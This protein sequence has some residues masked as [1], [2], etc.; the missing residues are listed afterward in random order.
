MQKEREIKKQEI[1]QDIKVLRGLEKSKSKKRFLKISALIILFIV[2]I[3]LSFFIGMNLIEKEDFNDTI[4]NDSVVNDSDQLIP[5]FNDTDI[6]NQTNNTIITPSPGGSSGGKGDDEGCT[7]DCT[8]KE[9]GNDGCGGICGVCEV[10][11]YCDK[12]SCVEKERIQNFD[13]SNNILILYNENSLDAQEIAEYYADARGMDYKQICHIKLPLG[14]FAT[15]EQLIG[16]RKVI[17]EECLCNLVSENLVGECNISRIKE[18]AAVSPITHLAIIR[19]IPPR[20]TGT[21][22]PADEEEPSLDFYLA[23][24]LY[25]DYNIFEVEGYG[26]FT[27][28]HYH[29]ANPDTLDYQP[30]F[31]HKGYIRD[32]D[33]ALDEF[34]AYGRVEAMTKERTFELIDRTIAAEKKGVSGNF[35]V[36]L[37]NYPQIGQSIEVYD[38]FRRLTSDFTPKCADYLNV[39]KWPYEECR[40]GATIGPIPGEPGKNEIPLAINAGIFLGHE[41]EGNGHN[42][43]DG[44]NNM[45]NWRKTDVDCITLCKDMPTEL[46]KQECKANSKD[47]F[48]EIN[49]DCVGVAD[50]FLGWQLISWPVQ[51]YGF[52]PSGWGQISGGNGKYEKTPPIILK[53]GA[54]QNS[55]FMDDKYLHF[56]SLDSVAGPECV[57][58]NETIVGC[59]EMI[60]V[61]LRQYVN[62][63]PSIYINGNHNFTIR[64]RHRNPENENA[65]IVLHLWVYFDSAPY[66]ST[67]YKYIDLNAEAMDWTTEEANF[68][69]N[70]RDSESINRV[71]VDVYSSLDRPLKRWLDLDGFEFIDSETG[72]NL[73][74]LQQASF[75]ATYIGYTQAGDYASN[76]IDRLGGI[77]WWGSSSHFLT[78]GYAFSRTRHFIGGFYSGRSLGESLLYVSSNGMSGI[79]YGDPAY[80]PS[81]VKIYVNNGVNN[82]N[83]DNTGYIF[84]KKD[85]NS[86]LYINAFHGQDNLNDTHW[87]LYFCDSEDMSYCDVNWEHLVNDTK[88]AYGLLLYESLEDFVVDVN[89]EQNFTMKLRVWNPSEPEND[90]TN[91]AYFKYRLDIDNDDLP[92]FWE[93]EH[94]NSP[95]NISSTKEG[96]PDVDCFWNIEEDYFDSFPN[97][98]YSFPKCWLERHCPAYKAYCNAY[99]QCRECLEDAHCGEDKPRCVYE[100]CKECIENEDCKNPAKPYCS[101]SYTCVACLNNETCAADNPGFPY[102]I[103]SVCEE[104]VADE[105]CL[106]KNPT[107]PHCVAYSCKECVNHTE[108]STGEYCWL[109]NTCK[110]LPCTDNSQCE[111][112]DDCSY[113]LCIGGSCDFIK[114]LNEEDCYYCADFSNCF[115]HGGFE[116]CGGADINHNGSVGEEDLDVFRIWFISI[117]CN[118]SNLFCNYSDIDRAP[119]SSRTPDLFSVSLKDL[120]ILRTKYN[121]T[122]NLEPWRA[123]EFGAGESEEYICN[124][125]FD[126]DC[127]DL[128]DCD[129]NDCSSFC[130]MPTLSPLKR[131]WNWIK[132]LFSFL[133]IS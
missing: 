64:F 72:E 42:A 63:S 7:P 88:S 70:N 2:L 44:F 110:P 109:D 125:W 123:C 121:Q 122:C 25:R 106:S 28:S 127:D 76:A 32:I 81:G 6:V 38:F 95:F 77:G 31:S 57:L 22:W 130:E 5:I 49:T 51:Y 19:G 12:R 112:F 50:G 80:R 74:D 54:Y 78:G 41:Y 97:S 26:A 79:I 114:F 37:I 92:D 82:L 113:D 59:E 17:V 10:L 36:S 52:W 45:L 119:V 4:L 21:G 91:Y 15:A 111:D 33:P 39:S 124:D 11:E 105:D 100:T 62:P 99:F 67:T 9:C 71:L 104:C 14:Q 75:N 93:Y 27:P 30:E 84:L 34:I 47:Y 35:L 101:D 132:D 98:D 58:E 85:I 83:D 66:L 16:V 89:K 20:L 73:L 1:P 96:D 18:I 116:I 86:K 29:G 40:V 118:E 56:G 55:Q 117:G 131:F 43:F 120:T 68:T 94:F 53:S 13:L 128:I 103:G 87:A 46:E 107:K 48:K 3:I 129:D 65:R 102:C 69:I 8:N 23:L 90:L 133:R 108:C 61:N 60:G 115:I 24:M 126:N